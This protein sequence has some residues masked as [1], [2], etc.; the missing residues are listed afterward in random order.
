M[1]E[2][3]PCLRLVAQPPQQLLALGDVLLG[4]DAEGYST[5]DDAEDSAP[6][7]GLG[8]HDLHR[9]GGR[10]EDPAHLRYLLDLVEHV[11]REALAQEDDEAV[12]GPDRLRV[13]NGEVDQLAVVS[14]PADEP[15]SRRLAEGKSEAE[16]GRRPGEGLA[17]SY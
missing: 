11:D 2:R 9:I 13:V 6:L 4:L 10:T 12:P 8:E 17:A 16:V 15:R 5:I 3:V 14:C 1:A 7:R